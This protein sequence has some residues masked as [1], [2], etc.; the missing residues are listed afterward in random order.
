[1]TRD[2]AR[3]AAQAEAKKHGV[4][5]ALVREGLHADEFAELDADGESYGFCPPGAVP[6]LYKYGKAVETIHP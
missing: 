1:M 6:Y 3:K 2:D 5:L 4:P